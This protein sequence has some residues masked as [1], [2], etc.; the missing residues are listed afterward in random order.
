[1]TTCI[2]ADGCNINALQM[3][4]SF[5]VFPKTKDNGSG[6]LDRTEVRSLLTQLNKVMDGMGWEED[7][8]QNEADMKLET[9]TKQKKP[10][11]NKL[12]QVAKKGF[13]A[14]Q[15]WVKSTRIWVSETNN[16]TT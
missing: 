7:L 5:N 9:S 11:A 2:H 15:W 13:L 16:N 12:N 14:R 6:S 4:P 10:I 8:Y 1:M 3:N